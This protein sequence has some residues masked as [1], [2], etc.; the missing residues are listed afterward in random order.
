M[1]FLLPPKESLCRRRPS[2]LFL[3][4]IRP[5][6]PKVLCVLLKILALPS[7]R[8]LSPSVILGACPKNSLQC[9]RTCRLVRYLL[10][11][12]MLRLKE[13]VRMF[14]HHLMQALTHQLFPDPESWKDL[15]LPEHRA[16]RVF[17]TDQVTFMFPVHLIPPR[18]VANATAC[19]PFWIKLKVKFKNVLRPRLMM[20]CPD[21]CALILIQSTLQ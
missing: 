13:E 2:R 3:P 6:L 12:T 21:R 15:L 5:C 17:L 9:L 8:H 18:V 1:R 19:N 11:R 16:R 14:R 10:N 20:W 4:K 7:L